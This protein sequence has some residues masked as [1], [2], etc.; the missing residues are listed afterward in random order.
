MTNQP[1]PVTD[2]EIEEEFEKATEQEQQWLARQENPYADRALDDGPDYEDFDDLADHE[3][4][5]MTMSR[6]DRH[7]VYLPN[8]Q[9]IGSTC[10]CEDY[11]CCG[12]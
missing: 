10:K 7:G 8:G 5:G 12:H 2:R 3:P 11:P 9:K 6:Y 4:L 1:G